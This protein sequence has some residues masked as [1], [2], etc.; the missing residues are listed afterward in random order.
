[1]KIFIKTLLIIVITNLGLHGNAQ[2]R[3]TF[4]PREVCKSNILVIT[5]ITEGPFEYTSF[6]QTSDFGKV[7]C[8]GLV[9]TNSTKDNVVGYFPA[10][11]I[12]FGDRLIK[13]LKASIGYLGDANLEEWSG[14]VQKVKQEY[15]F[16]KIVVPGHG[17]FGNKKLLDCTIKLFSTR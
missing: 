15:P 9:E 17:A 3:Y 8:N 14:A 12:M 16:M 5:Q 10:E 6:R 1:M 13:V 7:S 4:K 2:K 11:S